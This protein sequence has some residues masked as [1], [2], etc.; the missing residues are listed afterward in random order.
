M[1]SRGMWD[2]VPWPPG[3]LH[4]ECGSL[5]RWSTRVVAPNTVASYSLR[6]S[7]CT[8]LCLTFHV[9]YFCFPGMLARGW[10]LVK[11][12]PTPSPFTFHLSWYTNASAAKEARL[13]KQ[14]I[15]SLVPNCRHERQGRREA[16]DAV[17]GRGVL[18]TGIWSKISNVLPSP[19]PLYRISN[20]NSLRLNPP[21]AF[22]C[23]CEGMQAQS[24]WLEILVF[25]LE[26]DHE[27][28]IA[29]QP[30]LCT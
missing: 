20:S 17:E 24:L 10:S 26:W 27:I 16:G 15:T 19:F 5:S 29:L 14:E 11:A 18:Y 2:L 4:W 9:A 25:V 22:L 21:S 7:L 6:N 1:L 12:L 13:S 28:H 3:P 23:T 30:G 8:R